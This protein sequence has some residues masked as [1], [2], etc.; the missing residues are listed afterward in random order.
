[1]S[2]DLVWYAVFEIIGIIDTRNTSYSQSLASFT[3]NYGPYLPQKIDIFRNP[4]SEMRFPKRVNSLMITANTNS[5]DRSDF[6]SVVIVPKTTHFLILL[7]AMHI[8]KIL[9]MPDRLEISAN[10]K[11]L[12]FC[13]KL[14]L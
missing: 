8:I 6:I 9:L 3:N 14:L 5:E 12:Y 2:I 13:F 1:M 7:R 10:Q 4:T 11:Q